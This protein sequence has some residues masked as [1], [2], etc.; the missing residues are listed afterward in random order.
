MNATFADMPADPSLKMSAIPIPL[1]PI[2]LSHNE[3]QACTTIAQRAI[4]LPMR[5]GTTDWTITLR[6]TVAPTLLPEPTHRLCF[7]WSG[8]V[9]VLTLPATVVEQCI[10]AVL[11]DAELPPIPG[12]L[13]EAA[14]EAGIDDVLQL[15]QSLGRGS[16]QLVALEATEAASQTALP[17]HAIELLAHAA[18][19]PEAFHG[20]LHVD[21][22]GLLLIAGLM[23][24]RPP[25]PG[26]LDDSLP[27]RLRVELGR[28]RL[29][30]AELRALGPGDVVLMDTCFVH[31]S[32]TLWLTPDGRVGLHAQMS[33]D[34]SAPSL[35][36]THTWTHIMPE[37]K[38]DEDDES[39]HTADPEAA[40]EE[41][42]DINSLPMRLSFD[43]GDVTLPLAEL[44]AMQPG[45]TINLGHPLA[46]A[47]RIRA[48]GALLGEGDLVEINGQIGVSVRELFSKIEPENG[49]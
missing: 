25:V 6:P 18:G 15:L 22:L 17:V 8:A 1:Q 48:N 3:S 9:F 21:S 45:Q 46:G 23:S 35:V 14:L 20:S 31:A 2:H 16:P 10:T 36:V 26:P 19:G 24:K 13:S 4:G 5:L 44:H 39:G 29:L 41:P 7:E 11:E 30:E 34:P 49:R 28:T 38:H 47:V 12:A 33:N 27:V 32:R 40:E 42:S 43:L 37:H